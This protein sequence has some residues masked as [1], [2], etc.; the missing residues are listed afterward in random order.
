MYVSCHSNRQPCHTL[1]HNRDRTA[2]RRLWSGAHAYGIRSGRGH[3]HLHTRT[4]IQH[5]HT[6]T[7]EAIVK[8]DSFQK[9][10]S[11]RTSLKGD[12]QS[13]MHRKKG[14]IKEKNRKGWMWP[15]HSRL[16]RDSCLKQC[17]RKKQKKN[18][19]KE[20]LTYSFRLGFNHF[21]ECS[22]C[23]CLHHFFSG[24]FSR[25]QELQ[26][27]QHVQNKVPVR[28]KKKSRR[29]RKKKGESNSTQTV[30]LPLKVSL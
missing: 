22:S 7:L 28:K 14:R 30:L 20:S 10:H 23:L 2:A 25:V 6:C 9:S 27:G 11:A 19:T 15:I 29:R 5:T 1:Q 17:K 21:H 24:D 4:H 16:Q 26:L 8:R 13:S 18:K 3:T 12:W